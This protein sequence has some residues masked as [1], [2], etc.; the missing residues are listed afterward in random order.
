M[1]N[2]HNGEVDLIVGD[3]KFL[4]QYTI[5]QIVAL[6]TRT[7]HSLT[8]LAIMLSN[9]ATMT[10]GLVREVLLGGLLEK[11][12]D[13]TLKEAGELI[14]PA[15]GMTVVLSKAMEAMSHAF[16]E[17]QKGEANGPRPKQKGPARRGTGPASKLRGLR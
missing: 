16:P 10:V 2:V 12:P 5:D 11:Q 17:L 1:A 3:R 13:I 15:G 9:P 6:E 7:G 8:M 4:L 14:R